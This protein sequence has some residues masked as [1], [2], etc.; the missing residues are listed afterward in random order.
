MWYISDPD[1]KKF[2]KTEFMNKHFAESVTYFQKIK[3]NQ[4]CFFI[5]KYLFYFLHPSELWYIKSLG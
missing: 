2:I 1:K 5:S 4:I 3:L